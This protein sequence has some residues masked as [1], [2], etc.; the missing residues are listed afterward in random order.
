MRGPIEGVL[1]QLEDHTSRVVLNQ[2]SFRSQVP[3]SCALGELAVGR[4]VGI[5]Q[6]VDSFRGDREQVP[7]PIV[8]LVRTHVAHWPRP[9]KVSALAGQLIR[10]PL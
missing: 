2:R 1:E 9:P 4:D 3:E 7:V 6:A 5:D 10:A 8:V